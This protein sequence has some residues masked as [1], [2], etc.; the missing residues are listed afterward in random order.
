VPTSSTELPPVVEAPAPRV[1]DHT[2]KQEVQYCIP[3]WLRDEQIKL[4]IE[5]GLPRIEPVEGH[6]DEIAIACFGPSL[7]ETWEHLRGHPRIMTCSGAHKFLVERGVIP[8]WHVEVDPRPH[9]VELIGAPHPDVEYLIASTCHP[10]VFDHLAG[11]RVKLW[12]VFDDSEDAM[13]TLPQGEWALTGGCSVGLR[14]LT[15]ARFLGYRSMDVYGMDGCEGPTGKH[16]APHPNQAKSHSLVIVDGVEY[17]TTPGFLESARQT[18][19]ELDQLHDVK[20]RFHGEGLVQAMARSY[21]P[22]PQK[23][24]KIAVGKGTL[25]TAGYRKQ[26]ADLHR[27]RLE[28]GVGGGRHAPTVEKIAASLRTPERPAPSVLD[29]GCG[30]GYLAKALSFPIWEY[31]PAVPEKSAPPRA[32]DFVVCTDVL[33]HVEP[34][35][36]DAVLCDLLRCTKQ[37]GYFIIHTGPSMKTLADGRNAHLIQEGADW[38]RERIGRFFLVAKCWDRKPLLH[39]VVGPKKKKKTK[40]EVVP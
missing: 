2:Q 39:V 34:E 11:S 6:D 16:A 36:L 9:K 37:L 35:C 21:V 32:A 10:R 22:N 4:A 7:A 31:D 25:I 27:D 26:C 1:L 5:R 13:R 3:L 40:N 18:F 14:C 33:E 8:R 15:L 38:W 17:R 24:K 20:A 23:G 12:H 28:F 29:Y 19:H 30:K